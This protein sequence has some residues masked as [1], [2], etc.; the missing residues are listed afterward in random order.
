MGKWAGKIINETKAY[1]LRMYTL[2][3]KLFF[4]KLKNDYHINTFWGEGR[5]Y[6]WNGA[7]KRILQWLAK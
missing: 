2:V 5:V 3:L 1:L 6:N 7:H 4:K